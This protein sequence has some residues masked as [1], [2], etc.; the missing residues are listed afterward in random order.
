[1]LPA[2]TILY[3]VFGIKYYLSTRLDLPKGHL[4]TPGVKMKSIKFRRDSKVSDQDIKFPFGQT[5]FIKHA[6]FRA[7]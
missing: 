7:L 2:K 1:M 5:F 6:L 3:I 4:G